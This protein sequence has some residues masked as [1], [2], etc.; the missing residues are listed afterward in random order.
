MRYSAKDSLKHPWFKTNIRLLST[1]N[2][3]ITSQRMKTFNARLA[4]KTAILAT[5]TIIFWRKLARRSKETREE[6]E[7][8]T[9]EVLFRVCGS[10]DDDFIDVED[11][12][13]NKTSDDSEHD[14]KKPK[15]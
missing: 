12:S 9:K 4:F 13:E 11:E 14:T 10:F 2:L 6:R 5:H 1:N 8:K 7:A 15:V 3:N